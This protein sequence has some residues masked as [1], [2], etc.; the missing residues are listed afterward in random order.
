MAAKD[1]RVD[2]YI[3]KSPPYAHPILHHLRRVVHA[4]C[5]GIEETIK[6][7]A[8]HFEYKGPFCGMVAFKEHAGF[9]FWKAA[10]SKGQLPGG[11]MS[12]AGQFGTPQVD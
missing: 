7:S 5:P 6:W 2:A 1:P 3:K 8:P 12:P 4:A 9:G 11:G 10:L